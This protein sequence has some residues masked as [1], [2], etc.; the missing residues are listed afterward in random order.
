[1]EDVDLSDTIA[2]N[3]EQLNADDLMAGPRT[4]TITDVTKVKGEQPTRIHLAELPGRTYR[5][6]KTERRILIAAWGPKG[7]VY[8]GRRMTLYRD[9]AVKYGGVAVGGIKISHLSDIT[10]RLNLSLTSSQGQKSPRV[11]D[12]LPDMTTEPTA[13]DVAGCTDRDAL[14]AMFRASVTAERKDQIKARVA[15]LDATTEGATS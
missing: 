2:P 4:Y 7:A 3:S 5:P 13:D 15:E 14:R 12:P 11:I 10:G 1:M 6:S 8:V 9:P